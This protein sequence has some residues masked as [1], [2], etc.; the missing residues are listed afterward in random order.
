[1]KN[2][3]LLVLNGPNLNMLGSRE[4][5]VYGRMTLSDIEKAVRHKALKLGVKVE[6]FQT[7]H[8]GELVERVQK[9]RGRKQ[10][11]ILNAGAYTHTSIAIRDAIAAAETPTIEVHLSNVH[12]REPF[13]RHSMIADVCAGQIT[14]FGADSYLLAMEAAIRLA[15]R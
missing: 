7:N 12:A 10:V 4:P 8:E 2:L 6:F 15:D 9:T 5:G 11:I 13:R 3:S 1:M 14:G